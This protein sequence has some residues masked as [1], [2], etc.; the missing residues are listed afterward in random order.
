MRDFQDGTGQ[1]WTATVAGREGI[2]YKGRYHLVL[3]SGNE[4]VELDDVRWNNVRTAE[5]TVSTMSEV[6]LRRRLRS[7]RGRAGHVLRP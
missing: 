4:E 1:T 5:R 7:A 3:R 2:N 6:E